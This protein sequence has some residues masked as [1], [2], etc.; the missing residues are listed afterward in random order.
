MYCH[1][2]EG[3]GCTA[4]GGRGGT[5][6]VGRRGC[7]A[8][9]GRRGCTAMVGRGG[10]YCHGGE[11][12]DVLTWWGGG[13]C[14]D[15]MGRGVY[16]HVGR[17]Y[18]SIKCGSANDQAR[19]LAP[20]RIQLPHMRSQNTPLTFGINRKAAALVETL[21]ISGTNYSVRKQGVWVSKHVSIEG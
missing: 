1:D 15:M 5:A 10:V 12:G 14:T 13:R 3:G 17:L 8:M 20:Q 9:V 19:S 16:C 21:S 4:M 18:I 7:I 6:M 2:G 11:G